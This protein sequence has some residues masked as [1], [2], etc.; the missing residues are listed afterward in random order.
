MS[1]RREQAS[2]PPAVLPIIYPRS[3]PIPYL[4]PH[5]S[6][7]FSTAPY[8][9]LIYTVEYDAP[10][11][12]HQ[13][14]CR[15]VVQERSAL[16]TAARRCASPTRIRHVTLWVCSPYMAASASRCKLDSL[17][18]EADVSSQ[19]SQHIRAGLPKA[20]TGHPHEVEGL[21]ARASCE[22]GRQPGRRPVHR[23]VPRVGQKV[24]G[25]PGYHPV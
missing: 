5:S 13:G 11:Y 19:S 21:P 9:S 10:R 3:C 6:T 4:I 22:P 24:Q 20:P 25:R 15:F 17:S 8:P 12:D 23:S 16:H 7:N 1:T 14:I 18:D 2:H